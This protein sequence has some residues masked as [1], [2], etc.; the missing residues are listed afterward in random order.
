MRVRVRA[1]HGRTFIFKHLH[2]R[3]SL[4]QLGGLRLPGIDHLFQ[5]LNAQLR[6]RFAVIGREADHAAGTA[7]AFTAHQRIVAFRRVRRV[8]HQGGKIVGKHEGAFVVRV[9]IP[10][11]ARIAR[12][13]EAVRVVLRQRLFCR[14]LLRPLPGALSAVR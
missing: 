1:A 8:G 14:R 3:V 9:F 7:R 2:P 5:C 10:G 6:Q 11:D 12:T 13:E 4:T